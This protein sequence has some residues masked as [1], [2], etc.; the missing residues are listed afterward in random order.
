MHTLIHKYSIEGEG[1]GTCILWIHKYSI[2]GE[3]GG[4]CIHL[5]AQVQ[6]ESVHGGPRGDG[7]I[8]DLLSTHVKSE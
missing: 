6:W 7:R 3:G 2:E 1:G 8:N 4:T 5:I